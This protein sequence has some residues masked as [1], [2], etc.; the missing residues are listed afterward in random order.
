MNQLKLMNLVKVLEMKIRMVDSDYRARQMALAEQD[1]DDAQFDAQSDT[2]AD[3]F[4]AAS[5]AAVKKCLGDLEPAA[6]V[7]F[8]KG[9]TRLFATCARVADLSLVD[10]REAETA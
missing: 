1:L 3:E 4:T 5:D 8:Q 9:A 7:E 6:R 10:E 2:L